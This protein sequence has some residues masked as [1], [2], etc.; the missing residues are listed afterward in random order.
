M[1][2]SRCIVRRAFEV[3]VSALVA[4][5]GLAACGDPDDEPALTGLCSTTLRPASR[6]AWLAS[7][8]ALE[9]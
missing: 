5:G 9:A 4:I 2:E 7:L 1:T 8:R 3:A 6:P